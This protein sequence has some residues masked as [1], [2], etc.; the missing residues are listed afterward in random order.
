MCAHLLWVIRH[1]PWGRGPSL[2]PTGPLW[3]CP[4]AAHLC[5]QQPPAPNPKA[6][7]ERLGSELPLK[8]SFTAP[9]AGLPWAASH[10]GPWEDLE[11]GLRPGAGGCLRV[12]CACI[13]PPPVSQSYPGDSTLTV[14]PPPGRGGCSWVSPRG[15]RALQGAVA[16]HGP[17]C[18]RAG[19]VLGRLQSGDCSGQDRR[20]QWSATLT[21]QGLDKG[22]TG[23]PPPRQLPDH[24]G[25]LPA[26]R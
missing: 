21:C 4:R 5:T 2:E 18:P 9:N 26:A 22:S 3:V 24:R 23:L 11:R 15:H 19:L 10:L 12:L 7:K 14:C 16:T 6:R 8:A 20:L 1:R 25:P 13:L 17:S